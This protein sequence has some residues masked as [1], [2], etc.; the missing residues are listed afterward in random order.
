M[1][2]LSILESI[3]LGGMVL[4]VLFWF[5]P[6]IKGAMQQSREAEKDWPA[7]L[8]PLC[9]VVLFIIVLVMMV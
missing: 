3:L 5:M 9:L 8:M 1:G 6:G 4:L 7:L 2:N